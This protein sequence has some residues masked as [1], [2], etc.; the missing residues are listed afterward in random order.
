MSIA[1]RMA[2]YELLRANST[3]D[4]Y[5]IMSNSPSKITDIQVSITK[6]QPTHDNAN[7]L[8]I[9]TEY[10]GITSFV[11]VQEGDIL[12]GTGAQYRVEDIGNKGTLYTPLFLNKLGI[13]IGD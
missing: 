8:F 1:S 7:P 4:A 3:L 13:L 2:S 12:R 5:G 10:V 6:N 11:G 9:T